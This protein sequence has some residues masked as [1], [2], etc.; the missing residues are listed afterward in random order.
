MRK[1]I[2]TQRRETRIAMYTGKDYFYRFTFRDNKYI[3]KLMPD[4]SEDYRYLDINILNKLILEEQLGIDET[5]DNLISYTRDIQEGMKAVDT[6][7][8]DCMFVMNPVRTTQLSAMTKTGEKLPK[9]SVSI[10]PKP[11]TGVV[12]HKFTTTLQDV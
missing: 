11:A 9:R 3:D 12:I 1:Q 8:F 10:F 5:T 7:E 6:N 4:V 2:S